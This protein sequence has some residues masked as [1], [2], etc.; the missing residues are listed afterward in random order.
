MVLVTDC[1]VKRNT[2]PP[3]LPH[4]TLTVYRPGGGLDRPHAG[5]YTIDGLYPAGFIASR[6]AS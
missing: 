2:R 5:L 1:R 6:T 4:D 3:R